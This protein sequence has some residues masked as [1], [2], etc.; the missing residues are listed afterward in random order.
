[1]RD[2]LESAVLPDRPDLKHDL[3]APTYEFDAAGRLKIESKNDLKSRGL[4]STDLADAMAL[5]FAQPVP[6]EDFRVRRAKF[7][8]MD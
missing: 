3:L 1:M 4:P 6:W 2:W 8:V 7:A 5:T